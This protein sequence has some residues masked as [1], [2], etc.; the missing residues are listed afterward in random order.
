MLFL[1]ILMIA[2]PFIVDGYSLLNSKCTISTYFYC[3]I[4]RKSFIIKSAILNG[5]FMVALVILIT[6]S[7]YISN[8]NTFFSS[9][10][11][12]NNNNSLSIHA[13]TERRL[14]YQ[15]IFS[16]FFLLICFALKLGS[17]ITF[18]FSLAIVFSYLFITIYHIHHLIVMILHFALSPSFKTAFLRFYC[19]GF[20][21]KSKT[22][23]VPAI[24]RHLPTT[25]ISS[26]SR[27]TVSNVH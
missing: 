13:I 2:F 8:K 7:L 24:S 14:I 17:A 5:S 20:L 27:N 23:T 9:T 15:A 4:Y 21:V 12:N 1:I 3:Y 22:T 19:L 6:A 16:T 10:N 26:T 25:K 11:N 18:D